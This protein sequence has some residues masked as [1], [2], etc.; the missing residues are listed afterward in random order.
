MHYQKS[1]ADRFS[2]HSFAQVLR[3]FLHRN[4]PAELGNG[5]CDI[6]LETARNLRTNPSTN[7]TADMHVGDSQ[8]S[9]LT[10]MLQHYFDDVSIP[11]ISCFLEHDTKLILL[12]LYFQALPIFLLYGHERA[13]ASPYYSFRHPSLIEAC[14]NLL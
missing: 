14:A 11:P 9:I 4:E 12:L 5:V 13:R 7:N 1:Y 2:F 10:G 8:F 6:Q 3:M